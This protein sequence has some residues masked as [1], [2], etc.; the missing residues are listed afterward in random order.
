MG[1]R[2]H[3]R[4]AAAAALNRRL[5]LAWLGQSVGGGAIWPVGGRDGG[6]IKG[7]GGRP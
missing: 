1:A 6:P 3:G 4:R 7:G 5:D 2:T